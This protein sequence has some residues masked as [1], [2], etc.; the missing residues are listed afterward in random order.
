MCDD[1]VPAFSRR[2]IH[3]TVRPS[4]RLSY[5]FDISYQLWTPTTEDIGHPLSEEKHKLTTLT[6][7]G[8][9]P[10]LKVTDARCYGSASGI[11]KASLW[12]LFSLDK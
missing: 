2:I 8:V 9:Y 4:R 3:A 7:V 10:T 11:S 6:A 1:T 5:T 12:N